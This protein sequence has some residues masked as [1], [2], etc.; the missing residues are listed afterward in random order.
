MHAEL[1]LMTKLLV[2]MSYGLTHWAPVVVSVILGCAWFLRRLYNSDKGRLFFDRLKL[3][4]PVLGPLYRKVAIARFVR[5]LTSMLSSGVSLPRAIDIA[6]GV[7]GSRPI[8]DAARMAIED[9]QHGHP[10][11]TTLE[12]SGV[13][14]R[15]VTQMIAVGEGAGSLDE[16]LTETA[17]YYEREVEYTVKRLTTLLEPL[18]TAFLATIVGFVVVALYLPIF[19][20]GKALMHSN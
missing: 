8:A 3:R 12:R 17:A 18:L 4:L 1:P 13:F 10:M 15:M 2:L 6:A 14:P 16:M 7:A 11:S 20:L 19:G 5:T 9:I